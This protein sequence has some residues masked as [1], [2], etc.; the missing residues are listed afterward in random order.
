MKKI[1]EKIGNPKKKLIAIDN[2]IQELTASIFKKFTQYFD[3]LED[4]YYIV[5][6]D[7]DK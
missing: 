6:E 5:P 2:H 4:I 7:F 3:S 1:M